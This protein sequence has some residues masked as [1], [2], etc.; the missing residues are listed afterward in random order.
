MLQQSSMYSAKTILLWS[1]PRCVSTAFEKTF[2]Q[3]SDTVVVHE[4]FTDCYYFS[5]GRK[6][7]FYGDCEELLDYDGNQAIQK[8]QLNSAPIIFCKELA[9]QGLP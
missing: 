3:R 9:F 2:S 8:I 4:P 6:S 1:P 7:S 5:R